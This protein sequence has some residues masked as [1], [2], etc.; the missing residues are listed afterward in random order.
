MGHNIIFQNTYSP[1]L[2]KVENNF[3]ALLNFWLKYDF[4]ELDYNLVIL[5]KQ[6]HGSVILI[7]DKFFD[8]I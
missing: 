1:V 4:C 8:P 2:T 7:S 3:V 6:C 5:S